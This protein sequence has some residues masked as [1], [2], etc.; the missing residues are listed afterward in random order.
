MKDDNIDENGSDAFPTERDILTA[1][2]DA[3]MALSNRLYPEEAMIIQIRSV[4]DGGT[5]TANAGRTCQ[6]S[7][8]SRK[9]LND[10]PGQSY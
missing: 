5:T 2:L 7:W 6:T 10:Y 4:K 1:I 9:D 3:I 8:I